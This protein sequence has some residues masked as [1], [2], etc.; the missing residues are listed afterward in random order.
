MAPAESLLA[1]AVDFFTQQGWSFV[2]LAGRSA[3]QLKV[4]DAD[5]EWLCY[6]QANDAQRQFIFYSVC[7]VTPP[8]ETRPTFAEYLTRANFGLPIGNFEMDFEDGEVRFKTS[9]DIGGDQ[10]T[11]SLVGRLVQHN[12]WAVRKYLPGMLALIGGETSPAAA[13]ARAESAQT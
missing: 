8:T 10:L 9:I 1:T 12:L 5:A 4:S 13:I 3:L 2:Q 7:P 11:P 6:A